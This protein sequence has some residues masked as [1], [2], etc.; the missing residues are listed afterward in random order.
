[1][2]IDLSWSLVLSAIIGT[3]LNESTICIFWND[4]FEFQLLH[5]AKYISYVGINI[6]RL[7]AN[8]GRYIV[9]TGLKKKELQDKHLF[10]DDLVIKLILSIE[11]T[12]CETFVVF[13][14]D[15]D[16]FVDAFT[17]AS[18]YSIW[19]SLH[20]KFIFAHITNELQEPRNHFFE[21]FNFAH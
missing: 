1:M 18:V 4:K 10:L 20:N 19:R 17:K 16:R 2:L 15:I 21:V 13:D 9:D 14:K 7:N 6:D 3:Y 12:H 8:R 5:N 11:V